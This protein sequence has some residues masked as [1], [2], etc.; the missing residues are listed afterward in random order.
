[1][2]GKLIRRQETNSIKNLVE[3]AVSQ[4]SNNASRYYSNI[5]KLTNKLLGIEAGQRD[6]L[7]ADM[8][9]R[10]AML[11]GV[12]DISIQQSINKKL[13]YKEVYKLLKSKA[14]VVAKILD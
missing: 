3:Y 11:E 5:T 9:K 4:G 6:S 13:E 1:M 12:V 8:L 7:G 14:E 10:I 2:E